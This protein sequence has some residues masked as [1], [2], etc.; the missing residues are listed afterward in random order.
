MTKY[1]YKG[2]EIS[3]TKFL[4]ICQMAG[5]MGGRK[6]SH[7]E[8][9]VEM[10]E[11]GNERAQAILND[12]KVV[13]DGENKALD[14]LMDAKRQLDVE[15]WWIPTNDEGSGSAGVN[16]IKEG[17]QL[18]AYIRFAMTGDNTDCP[19]TESIEYIPV[20]DFGEVENEALD[21]IMQYADTCC[22]ERDEVIGFI[23][24]HEHYDLD[25]TFYI[26]HIRG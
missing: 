21:E 20:A 11:Q 16:F 5:V 4:T 18:D 2:E 1:I 14:A 26:A 25:Y 7:Y 8:K 6:K 13:K 24:C 23:V 17:E 9:L 3:H 15:G 19:N 22:L 12:L 10:A